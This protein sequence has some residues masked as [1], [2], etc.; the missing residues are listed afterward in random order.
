[1]P[2]Q[3]LHHRDPREHRRAAERR[4]RQPRLLCVAKRRV[5]IAFFHFARITVCPPAFFPNPVDLVVVAAHIKG[6]VDNPE[7]K[8]REYREADHPHARLPPKIRR[9]RL[10][11]SGPSPGE[12]LGAI[13][14][15]TARGGLATFGYSRSHPTAARC[16]LLLSLIKFFSLLFAA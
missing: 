7:E 9:R 14:G 11:P 16:S 10:K 15:E 13:F 12:E 6:R 5:D 2:V 8:S 4:L 3:C 1:V